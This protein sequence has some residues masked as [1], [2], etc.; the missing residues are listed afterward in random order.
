MVLILA[1]KVPQDKGKVMKVFRLP[2]RSQDGNND[3]K[4][5]EEVLRTVDGY[6]YQ[7]RCLFSSFAASLAW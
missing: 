4:G 1:Q 6:K 7:E 3:K 5:P 2:V